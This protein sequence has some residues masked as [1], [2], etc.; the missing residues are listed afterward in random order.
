MRRFLHA[1]EHLAH[2]VPSSIER[3]SALPARLSRTRPRS[4][5]TVDL[6]DSERKPIHSRRMVRISHAI[7][8]E[9]VRFAPVSAQLH[10]EPSGHGHADVLAHVQP[11]SEQTQ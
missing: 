3:S 1:S 11:P 4:G 10:P 5:G 2:H 8:R 6:D 9:S 7:L